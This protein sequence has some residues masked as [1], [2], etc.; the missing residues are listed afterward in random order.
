[1][2][3]FFLCMYMSTEHSLCELILFFEGTKNITKRTESKNQPTLQRLNVQ[4]CAKRSKMPVV[5]FRDVLACMW[6]RL[7]RVMSTVRLFLVVV[8]GGCFWW[9]FLVVVFSGFFYFSFFF[10]LSFF[11]FLSLF[12][13]LSLS[14]HV[15]CGGRFRFCGWNTSM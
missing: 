1:M 13:S 8:F 14:F 15:G 9:L 7:G 3:F 11:V 12:S 2:V 5:L 4:R 10:F 6:R